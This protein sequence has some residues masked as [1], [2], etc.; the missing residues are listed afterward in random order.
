MIRSNAEVLLKSVLWDLVGNAV[1]FPIW[2]YTK[3]LKRVGVFL[4]KFVGSMEMRLAVRVWIVNL[5]RPMY[6][7]A[8]IP[9][10]IISFF[11]RLF[12]IITRSAALIVVAIISFFAFVAYLIWPLFLAVMAVIQLSGSL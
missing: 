1:Y 5:F 2:W 12:M 11:M 4:I 7:V 6:A 3:G 9:G 10:R 8:D